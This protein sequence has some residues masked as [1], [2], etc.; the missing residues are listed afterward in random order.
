MTTRFNPDQEVFYVHQNVIR[1]TKVHSIKI[2]MN[3]TYYYMPHE[4]D[5]AVPDARVYATE[6]EC[7]AAIPCFLK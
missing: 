4:P 2:T 3:G 1:K 5:S 6:A 7:R